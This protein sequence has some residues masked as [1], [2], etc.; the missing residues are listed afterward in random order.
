MILFGASGHCKVVIEILKANGIHPE[1]ILDDFKEE[2]VFWG[3]YVRKPEPKLIKGKEI[4]ISVGDNRNRKIIHDKLMAQE[5]V[6][7]ATA[8]HPNSTISYSASIR[9]G[10]VMMPGAVINADSMIGHHSIINTNASVDHECVLGDFVHVSPNA[11]LCGLVT[12]GE[13][14]HIGAGAVVL[15]GVNIGRWCRIGAGT[16]VTKDVPDFCTVVGN[17]GRVIKEGTALSERISS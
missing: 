2:P 16:V 5:S 14:T 8:S 7:F 17:P 15:P 6:V 13:G 9:S 3:F 11:A 4:L 10:T 12:V 1:F